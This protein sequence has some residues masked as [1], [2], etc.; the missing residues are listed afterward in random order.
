MH[1]TNMVGTAW[2]K[3]SRP[4]LEVMGLPFRV[5]LIAVIIEV[6]ARGE[7][8]ARSPTTTASS[9]FCTSQILWIFLQLRDN[10]NI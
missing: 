10:S 7:N 8:G 6:T 2:L 3:R 5:G 1:G 4:S 9:S